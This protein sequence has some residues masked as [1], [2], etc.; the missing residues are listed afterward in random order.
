MYGEA[1]QHL[2]AAS[3]LAPDN[4]ALLSVL[5]HALAVSGDR[6]G[7]LNVLA[8]IQAMS[9]KRYVPSVYMA[10]IFFWLG[11]NP[12]TIVFMKRAP[13]E[14]NHPPIFPAAAPPPGPH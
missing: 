11:D 6:Q 9:H 4:A 8:Q 13:D 5:G 2:C 12:H 7:A 1:L 3:S 14:H 10:G